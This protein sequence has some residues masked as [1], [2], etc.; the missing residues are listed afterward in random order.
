VKTVLRGRV[1]RPA[2]L[3]FDANAPCIPPR[4]F[5]TPLADLDT[6]KVDG[7]GDGEGVGSVAV[8]GQNFYVDAF[9]KDVGLDNLST[10]AHAVG[11][12]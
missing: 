1:D 4:L 6:F 5:P 8:T 11:L 12:G 9:N 3:L 2:L 7:S 10:I